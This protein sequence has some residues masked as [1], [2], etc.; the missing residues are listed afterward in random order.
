V[1]IR[2][3]AWAAPFPLLFPA[4]FL[5][6]PLVSLAVP[7]RAADGI[8]PGRW[9]FS[10]QMQMPAMPQLPPGTHLPSGVQLQQGGGMS[11]THTSCI[12]PDRAVPTDPRPECRIERM[13]RNGGTVNWTTTCTTAQGAVHSEGVAQYTGDAMQATLTTHIPQPGGQTM[14]TAQ[15]ITGR[16]LGACQ[17]VR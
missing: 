8:K 5:A 17:Q 9:E 6:L 1:R 7:A 16:Y 12:E 4:I 3:G 13:Q 11:A 15:R 10:S 2:T 14:N